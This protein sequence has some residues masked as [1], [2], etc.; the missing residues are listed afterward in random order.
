MFI[1]DQASEVS[2][3]QVEKPQAMT[4]KRLIDSLFDEEPI[5]VERSHDME[6]KALA[7]QRPTTAVVPLSVDHANLPMMIKKNRNVQT[8]T[9]A[10][11]TENS[12]LAKKNK[13]V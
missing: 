13:I 9:V 5:V 6:S 12:F 11:Q 4:A 10:T 8:S 3:Q 2:V 1:L 7:R